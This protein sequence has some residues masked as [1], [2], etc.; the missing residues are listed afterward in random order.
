M[1]QKQLPLGND[2]AFQLASALKAIE[3]AQQEFATTKADFKARLEKLHEDVA[4]LQHEIL[5]GAR[6]EQLPLEPIEQSVQ[7]A[8]ENLQK[9]AD[10]DGTE[11]SVK[12]GDEP[13]VTIVKPQ[14]ADGK[15]A[16]AGA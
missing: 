8:V 10:K 3:D 1:T 2:P 5:T 7:T 11:L 12:I 9:I 4:R 14:K 13:P 6:Q 15:A 16:A